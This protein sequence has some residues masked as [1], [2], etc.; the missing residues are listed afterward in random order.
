[1]TRLDLNSNLVNIVLFFVG[2]DIMN[3]TSRTSFVRDS[4]SSSSFDLSSSEKT[5]ERNKLYPE[6]LSPVDT[7]ELMENVLRSQSITNMVC[8]SKHA[9]KI[10]LFIFSFTSTTSCTLVPL[11]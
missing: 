7:L 8:N 10:I 2:L 6:M 3:E 9:I 11:F 5:T 1:M 4:I